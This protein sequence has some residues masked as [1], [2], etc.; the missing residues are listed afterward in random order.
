[1]GDMSKKVL[2]LQRLRDKNKRIYSEINSDIIQGRIDYN[3]TLSNSILF[4]INAKTTALFN[5]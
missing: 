3:S 5:P 4:L 2:I 1:M